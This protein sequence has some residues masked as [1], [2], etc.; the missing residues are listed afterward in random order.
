MPREN[1]RIKPSQI[2]RL[3]KFVGFPAFET[4]NKIWPNSKKQL[5]SLPNVVS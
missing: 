3:T 1:N 5:A 2:I 4:N